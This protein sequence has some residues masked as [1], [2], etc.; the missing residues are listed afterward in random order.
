MSGPTQQIFDTV[1]RR[2]VWG[3]YKHGKIQYKAVVDKL[4][5]SRKEISQSARVAVS[6]VR[7]EENKIS[8]KMKQFIADLIWLLNTTYKYFEDEQK[9][10]Q[11]MNSPNPICGGYSPRELICLGRHK[12]LVKIVASYVEGDVP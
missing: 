8:K 11:W 3:I 7:Y 10:I 9:V 4:K 6:S 12:K 5:L 2:D 1:P